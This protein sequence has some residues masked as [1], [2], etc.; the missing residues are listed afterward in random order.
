M[1][2]VEIRELQSSDYL[3][4]ALF[5]SNFPEDTRNET[6]WLARFKY[7]WDEN[8]AYD[9]TWTR[10]FLLLDGDRIVGF[11]GSFPTLFKAG[12]EVV[13][14]FNGT[15]WRVCEDYRKFS[16]DLWEKNREISKDFYSFNT[17]PTPDVSKL[18]TLMG[19]ERYSFIDD[20]AS[21]LIGNDELLSHFL[22][23]KLPVFI[24]DIGFCILRL[25][26]FRLNILSSEGLKVNLQPRN[27]DDLDDLWR[28]TKD[29]FTHT[30]VRN[31]ESVEWYSKNKLIKYVYHGNT[32]VSY[33][34]YLLAYPNQR[35]GY[36]VV[37]VD[38]WYD[39]KFELSLIVNALVK[40]DISLLNQDK[41]ITSIRYPHYTQDLARILIRIGML[42][43]R[44]HFAG[45]IKRAKGMKHN[46]I[47]GSSYHTL[48]QGDF[49]T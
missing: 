36:Y 22:S 16:I 17:T 25:W 3:S 18:V 11:V 13:K 5:N 24:R 48:L 33:G 2:S 21:F 27:H 49:G 44:Y 32:L 4:L 7:W 40:S 45:Y 41:L 31:R 47:S 10:G 28:R 19:Y 6:E 9:E 14:A 20:K 30:N 23:G 43:Y 39:F 15:T 35:I 29:Q 38:F 34:I 12:D 8:P 46:S 1:K 42:K 37:L 26:Q